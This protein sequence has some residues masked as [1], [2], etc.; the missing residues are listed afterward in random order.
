[1]R[2]SVRRVL[3]AAVGSTAVAMAGASLAQD[4]ESQIPTAGEKVEGA[5]FEVKRDWG[6]FKLADRIAEKVKAGLYSAILPGAGQYYNGQKS[7]AYIM[8]GIEVAIVPTLVDRVELGDGVVVVA[9][10]QFAGLH[11]VDALRLGGGQPHFGGDL[12]GGL[13]GPASH[14]VHQQARPAGP[15]P[16]EFAGLLAAQ[17]GQVGAGW[18]GVDAAFDVAVGLAVAD[19]DEPATHG[20][21]PLRSRANQR[22]AS[23]GSGGTAPVN[24]PVGQDP[25]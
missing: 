15:A 3:F 23:S 7:K 19:Q 12:G 10:L 6:T 8:G 20:G 21:V 4:S 18:A 17:V 1:M 16:G 5:P 2:Q 25:R 14:R 22:S 24:D 13:R 11:L 9:V